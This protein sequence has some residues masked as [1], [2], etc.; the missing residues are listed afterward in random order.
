MNG[1]RSYLY[2]IP[3]SLGFQ[4]PLSRTP[5]LSPWKVVYLSR[6]SGNLSLSIVKG[7]WLKVAVFNPVKDSKFQLDSLHRISCFFQAH[8]QSHVLWQCIAI[9]HWCCVSYFVHRYWRPGPADKFSNRGYFNT[10][11][12]YLQDLIDRALMKLMLNETVVEPGV[13]LQEFPYP[14]YVKDKYKCNILKRQ[15]FLKL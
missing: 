6:H 1:S 15:L 11:F 3:S 7:I 2:W 4:L 13:Y 14:C 12:L 5:Q 8:A 9:P 10:G